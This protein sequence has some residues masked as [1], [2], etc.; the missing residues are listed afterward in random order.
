MTFK[1]SEKV[2]EAVHEIISELLVK[3]LKDPRIGFVTLTGVNL[4]DDLRLATVYFSVVGSE[5]EKKDTEK[6]LNSAKGYIRKEMGRNL[7]LRYVPDII[8]KYDDSLAYGNRIDNIL[9]DLHELN[10]DKGTDDTEDN[11]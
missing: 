11:Q 10:I 3:G 4:T 9:H 5:E 8:F 1:R 7:R 2:A 6:G